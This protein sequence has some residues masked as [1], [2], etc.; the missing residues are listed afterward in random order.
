VNL[1]GLHGEA[2]G[3][4]GKINSENGLKVEVKGTAPNA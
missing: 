4:I 1:S 3:E 2:I